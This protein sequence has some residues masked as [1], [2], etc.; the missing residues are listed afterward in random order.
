MIS[1]IATPEY[2]NDF[3][4][5]IIEH[6]VNKKTQLSKLNHYVRDK[7]LGYVTFTKNK[8]DEFIQVHLKDCKYGYDFYNQL[9][10]KNTTDECCVCYENTTHIISC[11]HTIC[12]SCVTN[13]MQYSKTLNCPLCRQNQETKNGLIIKYPIHLVTLLFNQE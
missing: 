3:I 8:N 10:L 12:D 1:K 9:L 2:I 6:L 4:I 7:L 11:G 5:E 13:I